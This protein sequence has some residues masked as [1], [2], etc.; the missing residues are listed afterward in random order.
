MQQ[1]WFGKTNTMAMFHSKPYSRHLIK[2]P[3]PGIEPGSSAWR[4]EI[5][6]NI[7]P[8]NGVSFANYIGGMCD[9]TCMYMYKNIQISATSAILRIPVSLIYIICSRPIENSKCSIYFSC[10]Y[11]NTPLRS[12][13]GVAPLRSYVGFRKTQHLS[14]LSI[15]D[16]DRDV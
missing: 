16:F 15:S 10:P 6:T 3:R 14:I 8:R 7:L 4:E 5:L 2:P 13:V 1:G 9:M 12:Y 11:N